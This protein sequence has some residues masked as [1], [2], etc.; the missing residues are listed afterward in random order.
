MVLSVSSFGKMPTGEEVTLFSLSNDTGLRVEVLDY[1]CRIRALY[2]PDRNGA[3]ADVVLGYDTLP[4]YLSDPYYLGCLVGRFANRIARASCSIDGV[5]YRLSRNHGRH[6]LH[7][8]VGGF[9]T[10]LWRTEIL[11]S[12]SEPGLRLRYLSVDGEEGYPGNLSVECCYQLSSSNEL[13]MHCKA[14][15]DK[16]TIV[17]CCN[18]SYFNLTGNPDVSCLNHDVRIFSNAFLV[19]DADLIPTGAMCEVDGTALDFRRLRRVGD[20]LALG[21][22]ALETAG[23]FDATWVLQQSSVSQ[24]LAA[25]ACDPVSGRCLE[26][27]TNQP[28]VQFYTGNFLDGSVAGKQGIAY[29]KHAGF[30]LETQFFPDAPHHPEF[31]P[32]ILRLGEKYEHITLYSFKTA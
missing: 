30:C 12:G 28:G 25:V 2:A 32:V 23:G 9:H 14:A 13:R 22:E 17:N 4:E 1:G 21:G 3:L 18:H 6:H 26:V 20:Q 11:S 8:G 15:T 7:G 31:P 16:P 10:R 27:R 5:S 24:A 29:E 19:T